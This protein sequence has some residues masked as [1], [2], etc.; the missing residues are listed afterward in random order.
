LER[1][2]RLEELKIPL[3]EPL[4]GHNEL[5]GVL[6][7]PEWWPTGSRV[8]LVFAHSAE[9]N[10][11][12]ALIQRV[13]LALTDRKCLTLRFNFPFAEGKRRKRVDDV[14]VLRRSFRAAIAVLGRDPA[15]T[16]GHLFLGGFGLGAQ[17]AADL[18]AELLPIDGACLFGYPL[19]PAG[20]P[21]NIR[22]ESLYRVVSPML[23][24]QGAHDPRCEIDSLRRTLGRVGAPINLHV[25]K[26]VGE[27]LRPLENTQEENDAVFDEVFNTLSNWLS[28]I[29][30]EE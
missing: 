14:A 9:S 30:E 12:D 4:G 29:L 26:R 13:Q 16:P 2:A 7:I 10:L 8:A 22:A 24:V 3:P 1:T 23:F 19:H 27:N 11:D 6:G 15:A 28:K 5:S 20:E 21:D 25:S 17:I 18:A